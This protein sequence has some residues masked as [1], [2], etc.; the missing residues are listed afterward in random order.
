MSDI[1]EQE[2]AFIAI[3]NIMQE[4][5]IELDRLK[6][7]I[8]YVHK[9][10]EHIK[11]VEVDN[12]SSLI[13]KYMAFRLKMNSSRRDRRKKYEKMRK[14]MAEKNYNALIIEL[15]NNPS[16]FDMIEKDEDV[17]NKVKEVTYLPS[18][19]R[20]KKSLALFDT[21]MWEDWHQMNQIVCE[22]N[23]FL[24]NREVKEIEK[25]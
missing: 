23:N 14:Y 13:D 16:M 15:D 24:K 4:F 3:A 20:F 17:I 21:L 19:C 22:I 8:E 7:L 12:A 5:K 2:K 1:S 25:N 10:I 11:T 6:F 9:N 18:A